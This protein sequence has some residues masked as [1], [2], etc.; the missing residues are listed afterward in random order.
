MRDRLFISSCRYTL[1]K[2]GVGRAL[3]EVTCLIRVISG[4]YVKVICRA[5]KGCYVAC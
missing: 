1:F 5:V 4:G 3:I 2:G